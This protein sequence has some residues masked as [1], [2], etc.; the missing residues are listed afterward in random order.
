MLPTCLNSHILNNFFI[1][2]FDEAESEIAHF[3]DYLLFGQY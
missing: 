2:D 1:L 3:I